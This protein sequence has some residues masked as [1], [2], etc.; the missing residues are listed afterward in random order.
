MA[1][2]SAKE[3]AAAPRQLKGKPLD[4]RISASDMPAL[5]KLGFRPVSNPP[6]LNLL[7][8]TNCCVS[9]AQVK[10][11]TRW[12]I[13]AWNSLLQRF[14]PMRRASPLPHTYRLSMRAF[15]HKWAFSLSLGVLS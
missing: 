8:V 3:P 4:V 5:A 14:P 13:W 7:A 11:K 12:H 2:L 6:A 15:W 10:L 9:Y 1:H